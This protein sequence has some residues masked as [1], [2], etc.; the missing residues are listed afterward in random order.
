MKHAS[1]PASVSNAFFDRARMSLASRRIDSK[2]AKSLSLDV[3]DGTVGAKKLLMAKL[4][5]TI[6][7]TTPEGSPIE[8]HDID[9]RPRPK[10]DVRTLS[11][12]EKRKVLEGSKLLT[13]IN[14]G[15][16]YNGQY[17]PIIDN[18]FYAPSGAYIQKPPAKPP[19]PSKTAQ[20]LAMEEARA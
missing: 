6:N 12:E 7:E 2:R 16:V 3:M 17:M 14:C 8:I 5:T 11:P 10:T 13:T 1:S 15:L 9:F 19:V 20:E 18:D 4:Q